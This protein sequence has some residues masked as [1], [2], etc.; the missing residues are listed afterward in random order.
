MAGGDAAAAD[1]PARARQPDRHAVVPEDRRPR[2][3]AGHRHRDR[4]VAEH[5]GLRRSSARQMPA[6]QGEGRLPRRAARGVQPARDR[7]RRSRRRA[8]ELGIAPGR[9]RDRHG[10]AAARLEGQLVPRR[11]RRGS[12]S[13]ERPQARFFVVGEG[14][15]REPLEAAGARARPW[16]SV[17][18]SPASR[19]TSRACVSAFDSSVFPSL[20]EGTP[21]TVFEALAMGKPIVATDADGLLDVLDATSRTRS[22]VPKR[23]AAR[24]RATA[25][26]PVID[27]P[28]RR[29]RGSAPRRADRARSTTSPRSSGRWSGST[30]CCT[31]CRGRRTGGRPRRRSVVPDEQAPA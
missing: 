12:C 6:E 3:R 29:A 20:W 28:G 18:R 15:L 4:G 25:I 27:E 10:H 14:P 13:N 1:D 22:I 8:R 2:A 5:G 30:T 24:A 26:D 19:R 17:R 9:L 7:R 16:R 31:A 23:D 21:L 11:R